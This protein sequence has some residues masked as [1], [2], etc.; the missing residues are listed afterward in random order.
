MKFFYIELII[1]W[2]IYFKCI[3]LV[4]I[5]NYIVGR[6]KVNFIKIVYLIFYFDLWKLIDKFAFFFLWGVKLKF[7][8]FFIEF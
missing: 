1:E 7:E 2:Y 3:F 8:F 6:L 5:S 4:I